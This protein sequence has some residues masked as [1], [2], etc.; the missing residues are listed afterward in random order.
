MYRVMLI[1]CVELMVKSILS[2]LLFLLTC[3]QNTQ[4]QS[5]GGIVNTYVAVTNMSAN[6]VTVTSTAG[7]FVSDRVLLIQMKGA[8]INQTNT[9]SFGQVVAL[10]SAGNFEFT[11]IAT[12]V[13][14]NITFV[15]NLC[16][17]FSVS[18]KVQLIRVPVY[19]QAT[20]NAV[21]TASP[22]NGN[23]GGVVAIEASTSLTFNNQIN[24]S[25][26]GFSGGAF[27]TGLFSCNDPN[28]ASPG[29]V[30]GKKG[31]GVA[32]APLNLDGNRAPLA[33]GGGGSNSGN[34]GAAG[35]SNGGAGGRGG[36]Q[37]SGGCPVNTAFGMG[38]YALNYSTFRAYLGGGGGGGYK[39]NGLN[40]TAG[41]NGGG[42][43]FITTPTIIGN[44]QQIFATGLNVLGNT[45]SEGA[46]GAGSGGCVYLLTQNISTNLNIDVKGGNGG[47]ILS[48]LWSSACHGP[49][50]G[51]GGGA[52]V[53]Q[54]AV[55]PA[56][57]NPILTGGNPGAVL[58]TGPSCAGTSFGA[59]GGAPGILVYNYAF[60][61]PG[62][63]PNL[64]PD[65]LICA[66]T[67]LTIQPAATY[68]S[69][70][71][72][73]GATTA[74]ISI[75]A[76]GTYWLDV[77]SGCGVARDSIVVSVQTP[78]VDLGPDTYHC[79][80][81]SSLLQAS[82]ST[83][84]YLW[85]TGDTTAITYVQNAGTY[86]LNLIDNLGCT[87][88]DQINITVS[89]PDTSTSNLSLC[90]GSSFSFFG[91]N[92]TASGTYQATL[93]NDFGCDSIVILS[94]SLWALPVVSVADTFVCEGT[95]VDLV[96]FGAL[97][98]IWNIP[99]NPNG[100]STVCPSETTSYVVFGIDANGCQS[101][102]VQ[103]TVQIYPIP[104]PSFFINPDQLEID[105][106]TLT[107]F[108]VT[109]GNLNHFWTINTSSF[110]NN[111]SSFDYQLPFSEGTYSVQLVSTTDL[112]CTDSLSATATVSNNIAVYVPNAFT[113]DN[114][115]FNTV[116]FPVFSTG[117]TPKGYTFSIYNRWG[118][119]IFFSQDPSA[120]WDGSML[121]GTNCPDG[122]YNYILEY[123]EIEKG[124][125][126]RI[127][128]F[129]SLLR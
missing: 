126:R 5:I 9:A 91:Q 118:E 46:G 51:G 10:G 109:A 19:N 55:L 50:G 92:I 127:L 64:G 7:F 86:I 66:G 32:Q 21:I 123:Q 2:A 77:P 4:A 57:V 59:Q 128:G 31:E 122:T 85:S 65:T 76:A 116:F 104:E 71:W 102:P 42:I 99:Q 47:N 105:D 35:G 54:Q 52:I 8:T 27:T 15:S 37:F 108:N 88:Q 95:C 45:D 83:G 74:A 1:F 13:G 6:S 93:I 61:T 98:Y 124:E 113:P 24:V 22:W 87:A 49:G 82:G 72:S 110:Q 78:V 58:H 12:I 18:G 119:V 68:A 16:K 28:F 63:P 44:N 73:T 75:T 112:G 89:M 36:N 40:A 117:F 26:Q 115:E 69:Y 125:P 53:F 84:S 90:A 94:F 41:S 17:P 101:L 48:T 30:A 29:T 3:I 11:N 38:G 23:T 81:D 33:N 103:P 60:P 107:I 97:N 120:F 80:G 43:V 67:T 121:D 129:V 20:I 114:N 106:P 56:N 96:P 39:D 79:L 14:N 25:G 111:Q 70:T 62:A 34:P 100:S